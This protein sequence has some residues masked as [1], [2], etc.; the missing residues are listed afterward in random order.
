MLL[1]LFDVVGPDTRT[2]EKALKLN[3]SSHIPSRF[4]VVEC[5]RRLMLSSMLI[6]IDDGSASQVVVA[7]FICLV[8]IKVYSYYAPFAENENDSLAEVAQV[9]KNFC[10]V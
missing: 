4:E 2:F 7:I 5:V 6:L 1:H 10:S 8:S 9:R 3:R